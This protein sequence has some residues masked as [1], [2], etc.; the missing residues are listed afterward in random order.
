MWQRGKQ[1]RTCHAHSHGRP[2]AGHEVFTFACPAPE[3]A[4][5]ARKATSVSQIHERIPKFSCDKVGREAGSLGEG[6][7]LAH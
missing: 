2:N 7:S 3:R 1:S 4:S 5:V 6:G